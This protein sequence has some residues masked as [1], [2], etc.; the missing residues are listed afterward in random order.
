[1]LAVAVGKTKIIYYSLVFF[2]VLFWLAIA[3]TKSGFQHY[4][5]HSFVVQSQSMEPVL[6]PGSLVIVTPQSN[7][8]PGDIITYT[9]ADN[10][11]KNSVTH[12]IFKIINWDNQTMFITKGDANTV[13]DN[14]IISQDEIIG[15]VI[16]Q[17][18]HLGMFIYAAQ[19]PVGS[20]FYVIL[21]V[22]IIFFIE[23]KNII[24]TLKQ[25]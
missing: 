23:I 12:R 4:Q 16:Y 11:N 14:Q 20:F 1:M 15:K 2:L 22:G 13:V 21:P 25:K 9:L 19:T 18:P 5:F 24:K 10:P 7:Y 6:S 17:I 8:N 3:F